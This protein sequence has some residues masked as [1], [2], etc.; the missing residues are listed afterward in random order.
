MVSDKDTSIY[1]LGMFIYRF[2]FVER[3][4]DELIVLVANT[5]DEMVEIMINEVSF[6]RKLVVLDVM[7]ARFIDLRIV[8]DHTLRKRFHKLIEEI[9]SLNARRNDLVHSN[10]WSW[11]NEEGE[12][13]LLRKKSRLK[14]KGGTREETEEELMPEAFQKDLIKL[15]VLSLDLEMFRVNT[16]NLLYP[17]DA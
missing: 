14:S 12:V 16:I 9:K 10:Y 3:Q 1:K 2:Q 6:S 4:I 17:E 7:F 15:N 5:D 11:L 13:G 8:K